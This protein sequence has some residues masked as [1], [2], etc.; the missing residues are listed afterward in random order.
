M[1]SHAMITR[2]KAKKM[3]VT[4]VQ[5]E[6]SLE[7]ENRY[8]RDTCNA[9]MAEN[10]QLRARIKSLEPAKRD[11]SQMARFLT[12]PEAVYVGTEHLRERLTAYFTLNR[13]REPVIMYLGTDFK[14][15][16]EFCE[17]YAKRFKKQYTKSEDDWHS[18]KAFR[19]NKSLAEIYDE[20]I[21]AGL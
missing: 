6:S 11:F 7:S 10:E 17:Y 12:P 16:S 1:A 3:G 9:L 5:Q 8:L 14:T 20:G 18:V 2:S 15:P 19:N 21:K 13:K 4:V